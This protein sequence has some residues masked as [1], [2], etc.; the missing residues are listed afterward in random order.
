MKIKI[1][2][3]VFG[4]QGMGKI[5]GK[6]AFVWNALPGEEVE[7]RV[8]K[9]KSNF[10]EAIAENIITPSKER[11][12]EL[13]SH[14]LSCSPWQILGANAEDYWKKEIARETF[15]KFGGFEPFFSL[16]SRRK[17]GSFPEIQT[18]DPVFQRD[19][20]EKKDDNEKRFGYR[21]KMEY[22]FAVNDGKISLAF[23]ERGGRQH[24]HIDGCI[25]AEDCINVV[26]VQILEWINKV[27]IPMRSLK[28]LILRSNGQ[29]KTIVALFIKDHLNFE[30][31]P[32]LSEDFLGFHIYYS[33]YLTPASIPHEIL[34]TAGQN[35]LIADLNG[36][37]LKFGLLSFF[38]INVP[39]FSQVLKDIEKF[40][41][42]GAH[43]LDFYSGVGAIGIPLSKKVKSCVCVDN[44][45]EAIE[46]AVENIALNDLE[47][48]EAHLISA[49]KITEL[50]TSDKIVIL[51]PP[52]EGLHQKIVERILETK[53]AK[54]IYL[55]CN[56]TTQAR[57]IKLL[58]NQYTPVFHQLYN[59]FPATQHVES[60]VILSNC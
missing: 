24:T 37:K 25:L 46:Y 30:D 1:D 11:I 51:D 26:A 39:L 41:D 23:F 50:I 27:N 10:I 59:F 32:E 3:L 8:L 4:G 54:V 45:K 53:P 19:D 20:N 40:L 6:A 55:S 21:N 9:S 35:Y 15:F 28:S 22:S 12:P 17:P 52:R 60:L 2:K 29:G 57:D 33:S 47:N 36:F 31:C 7:A 16:S 38:Q 58:L 43:I 34:Y 5:D 42:P 13:E 14:Y 44:N 18:K 56:L 48:Y 49:E